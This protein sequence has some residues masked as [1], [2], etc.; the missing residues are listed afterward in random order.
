MK[1]L[2]VLLLTSALSYAVLRLFLPTANPKIAGTIGLS[3]ML[4]FTAIGHFKFPKGMVQMLPAFVPGR[5]AIVLISGILEI[6]FAVG[7]LVPATRVA[8]GW[9]LILFFTALLPANIYAASQHLNYETG[10]ANG[11]GLAYLW[12]R[13]PFQLLLLGWAC[14][15]GIRNP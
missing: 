4:L 1:P 13:I 12:F 11:P 9:V 15:F 6:G 8:T 7:L 5:S 14:Y 10:E 2:F 3:L